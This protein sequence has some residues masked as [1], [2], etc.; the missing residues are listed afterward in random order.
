MVMVFFP[1][2]M[3]R[4]RTNRC[5]D[6]NC[7]DIRCHGV[8]EVCRHKKEA[9]NGVGLHVIQ[10]EFFSKTDLQSPLDHSNAGVG[11]VPMMLTI[12]SCNKESIRECLSRDITPPSN[13][14]I[15]CPVR[16]TP[17]PFIRLLP[18]LLVR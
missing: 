7:V 14:R 11:S 16:R 10:V 12:T 13:Q 8:L 4:P 17:L 15:L 3:R 9:A 5:T 6:N 18:P 2:V 1:I